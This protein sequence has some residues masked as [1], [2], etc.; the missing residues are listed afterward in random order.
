M[1]LTRNVFALLM[2][3]LLLISLSGCYYD[4]EEDLYQA[5]NAQQCD[6][7]NVTFSGTILPIFNSNCNS[8]HSTSLASGGIILDTYAGTSV[9]AANGHLWGAVSW[10][11]GFFAMPN[12]GYQLNACDLKKI[13]TWLNAGYKNN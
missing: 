3:C 6:T 12:G 8:C 10:T 2:S 7:S 5:V 11:A 9:V 1:R 4:N 13:K